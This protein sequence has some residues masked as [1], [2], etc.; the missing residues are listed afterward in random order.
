MAGLEPAPHCGDRLGESDLGAYGAV[1]RAHPRG[2]RSGT[3][4]RAI[5]VAGDFGDDAF[6]SAILWHD[7]GRGTT[8]AHEFAA[9]PP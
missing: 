2:T 1:A 5:T 3:R 9:T 4:A 8:E 7:L 6:T